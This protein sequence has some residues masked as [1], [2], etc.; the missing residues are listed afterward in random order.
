[1]LFFAALVSDVLFVAIPRVRLVLLPSIFTKNGLLD[2]T[3][4][5]VLSHLPSISAASQKH[6]LMLGAPLDL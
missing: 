5:C 3:I 2:V 4:E 1:M 6:E